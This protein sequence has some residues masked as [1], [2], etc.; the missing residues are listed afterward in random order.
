MAIGLLASIIGTLIAEKAISA[1][2]E[3][4]YGDDPQKAAL[5]AGGASAYE[6]L[7]LKHLLAAE[8]DIESEGAEMQRGLARSAMLVGQIPG[9]RMDREVLHRADPALMAEAQRRLNPS[10]MEGPWGLLKDAARRRGHYNG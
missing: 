7:G 4:A 2:I 1:G 5:E 6:K 9:G 3:Y 10:R 8:A